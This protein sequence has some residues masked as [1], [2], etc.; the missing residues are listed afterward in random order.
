MKSD[1]NSL[2]DFIYH[3]SKIIMTRDFDEYRALG[4]EKHH[5]PRLIF[6][7]FEKFLILSQYVIKKNTIPQVHA[8]NW[9]LGATRGIYFVTT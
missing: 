1:Q 5:S 9:A 8:G 4:L 6:F 7:I 3:S 2:H